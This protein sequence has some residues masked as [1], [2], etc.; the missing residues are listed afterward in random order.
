MVRSAIFTIRT[1]VWLFHINGEALFGRQDPGAQ[2]KQHDFLSAFVRAGTVVPGVLAI[3]VAIGGPVL[4][5]KKIPLRGHDRSA[6]REASRGGNLWHSAVGAADLGK[7]AVVY[8]AV[9]VH[10]LEAAQG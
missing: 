1:S 3:G 10:R 4:R 6:Q 7:K 5:E 8:L 2:T 9:G